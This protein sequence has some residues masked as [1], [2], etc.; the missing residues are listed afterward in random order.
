MINKYTEEDF[1]EQEHLINDMV[2]ACGKEDFEAYLVA[3][4]KVHDY[5]MYKTNNKY[6][7]S[8]YKD[9]CIIPIPIF[10]FA[11]SDRNIDNMHKGISDHLNIVKC[12]KAHDLDGI[13]QTLISHYG[14]TYK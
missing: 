9:I 5:Y 8:I 12:I 1:K 4:R 2:L 11:E 14:V 3:N 6:L 10:Y 13:K 7:I